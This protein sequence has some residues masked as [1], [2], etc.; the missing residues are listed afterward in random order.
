M[1]AM[2]KLQKEF[3]IQKCAPVINHSYSLARTR[4][5]L[6]WLL[7]RSVKKL[8]RAKDKEHMMVRFD[9]EEPSGAPVSV[10]DGDGESAAS[11]A[12]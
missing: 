4:F 6:S 1:T 9:E 8:E 10:R 11:V 12:E 7:P 3:A 2:A 5:G